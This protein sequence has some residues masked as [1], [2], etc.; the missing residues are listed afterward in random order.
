[1]ESD[2]ATFRTTLRLPSGTQQVSVEAGD[3]LKAKSMLEA[4]YGKSAVPYTVE[5]D[6]SKEFSQAR[7]SS[8]SYSSSSSSSC[9]SGSS[10]A[11]YEEYD[12]DEDDDVEDD[13]EDDDDDYDPRSPK[14]KAF[15]ILDKQPISPRLRQWLKDHCD[16]P[17]DPDRFDF[18]WYVESLL[19]G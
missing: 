4:Q 12:D 7:A 17:L 16:I 8:S 11:S 19:S 5:R 14:E 3:Y 13:D 2:M 15:E 6:F 1:M 10:S 9:S 18:F